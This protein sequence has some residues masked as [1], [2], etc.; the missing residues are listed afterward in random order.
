MCARSL[1]LTPIYSTS[2]TQVHLCTVNEKYYSQPTYL[3]RNTRI[4][5]A[6]LV[7]LPLP[8]LRPLPFLHSCILLYEF[9]SLFVH[10]YFWNA[11]ERA[12][13]R[14]WNWIILCVPLASVHSTYLYECVCVYVWARSCVFF[15]FFKFWPWPWHFILLPHTLTHI[16][17]NRFTIHHCGFVVL[18][19]PSSPLLLLL[20]LSSSSSSSLPLLLLL[21]FVGILYCVFILLSSKPYTNVRKLYSVECKR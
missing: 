3:H 9:A 18:L 17:N 4:R 13:E 6:V 20:L 15:R 12:S 1:A 19:L 7:V 2:T 11:N 8:L 5:H 14:A 10:L 16:P 21:P